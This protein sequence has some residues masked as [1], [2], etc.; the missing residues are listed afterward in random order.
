M[1]ADHGGGDCWTKGAPRSPI[2]DAPSEPVD[3]NGPWFNF[4]NA[5]KKVVS[6][7]TP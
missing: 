5:G 1:C 3:I 7:V 4:L 2:L 6:E